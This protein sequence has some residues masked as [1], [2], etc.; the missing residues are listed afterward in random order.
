MRATCS[1]KGQDC[2]SAHDWRSLV[3]RQVER[4]DEDAAAALEGQSPFGIVC[5]CLPWLPRLPK[6]GCDPSARVDEVGPC[7]TISAK[8]GS[9]A[10]AGLGRAGAATQ[11]E[12]PDRH[13]ERGPEAIPTCSESGSGSLGSCPEKGGVPRGLDCR[14][15]LPK[16]WV[17]LELPPTI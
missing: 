15:H 14:R 9:A 6:L 17:G 12:Q 5:K 3:D 1:S 10:F 2:H 8:Q 4:H 16:Q 13:L 7:T 11:T